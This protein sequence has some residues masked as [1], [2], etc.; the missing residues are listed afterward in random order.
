MGSITGK[1]IRETQGRAGNGPLVYQPQ[2]ALKQLATHD[3]LWSLLG[4]NVKPIIPPKWMKG[5]IDALGYA[6][7]KEKLKDYLRQWEPRIKD[8]EFSPVKASKPLETPSKAPASPLDLGQVIGAYN[9]HY[10]LTVYAR[11]F[12]R[13][14]TDQRLTIDL[15]S[16]VLTNETG[17]LMLP[18]SKTPCE[19]YATY[20]ETLNPVQI[21]DLSVKVS[22]VQSLRQF[23]DLW[24]TYLKVH[25]V[26]QVGEIRRSMGQGYQ[27]WREA[28]RHHGAKG[29]AISTTM[30]GRELTYLRNV[31]TH[32]QGEGWIQANPMIGVKPVMDTRDQG[33]SLIEKPYTLEEWKGILETARNQYRDMEDSDPLLPARK[34]NYLSILFLSLCGC[35]PK[36]LNQWTVDPLGMVIQFVGRKTKNA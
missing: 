36:E 21:A 34:L 24:I 20:R 23:G 4:E 28:N 1:R 17:S 31:L 6:P 18:G 25:K 19:L 26:K 10:A 5:I 35:R 16:E 12:P 14:I 22:Q 9:L 8:P 15:I 30:I 33:E 13:W 7:S 2:N 11:R 3:R 29:A 27:G 32:A